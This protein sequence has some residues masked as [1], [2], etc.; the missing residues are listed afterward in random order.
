MKVLIS[1]FCIFPI[2][3]SILGTS[4]LFASYNLALARNPE[5]SENLFSATLMGF[6]LVETF[7][8]LSFIVTFIL[9]II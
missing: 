2:C 3:F 7:M 5:E 6:A 1:G 4:I 9:Y 8:F